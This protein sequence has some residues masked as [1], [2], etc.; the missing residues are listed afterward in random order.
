MQAVA[1]FDQSFASPEVGFCD[2]SD[3]KGAISDLLGGMQGRFAAAALELGRVLRRRWMGRK[4]AF[5]AVPDSPV[6]V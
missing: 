4:I 1:T 2:R 3:T 6:L 5:E